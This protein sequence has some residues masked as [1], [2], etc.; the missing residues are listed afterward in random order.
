MASYLDLI[1]TRAAPKAMPPIVL[2]WP[3]TLEA[4][5]GGM[6]VETEPSHQ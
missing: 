1:Y 6:T 3:V 2:C 5:G 4:D